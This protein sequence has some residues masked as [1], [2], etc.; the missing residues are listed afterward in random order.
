MWPRRAQ[1]AQQFDVGTAGVFQ[2]VGE[3]GETGDV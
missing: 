3:Q 1:V 2:G